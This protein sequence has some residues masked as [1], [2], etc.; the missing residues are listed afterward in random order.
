MGWAN[1]NILRRK[2]IVRVI[3]AARRL[4]VGDHIA[5]SFRDQ[6]HHSVSSGNHHI[7]VVT[8]SG[9]HG[10]QENQEGEFGANRFDLLIYIRSVTKDYLNAQK[11]TKYAFI[12]ASF[13]RKGLVSPF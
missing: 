12:D 13:S 10:E 3:F 5:P 8:V 6:Y 1:V 2:Q 7:Y 9:S 4:S 11:F